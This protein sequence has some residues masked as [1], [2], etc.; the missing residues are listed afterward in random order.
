MLPPTIV[1]KAREK[2]LDAIGITDHNSAENVVSV[3]RAAAKSGLSVVMGMEITSREDVHALAYF[4]RE[5]ELMEMQGFVYRHLPGSN[6]EEKFGQQ[7]ITDKEGEPCDINNKLLIGATTLSIGEIVD[8]IHRL[9]GL[10]VASHIDREA[11]G[12]LGQLGF[13]PQ[14]LQLDA[15][16][17][18]SPRFK[19][20]PAG[21]P[22]VTSSDAHCLADIGKNVTRFCVEE[23]TVPEIKRALLNKNGRFIATYPGHS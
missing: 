2:G 18:S 8:T 15:L 12:I 6:D 9:N 13:I 21:F 23:M 11:Y 3:K 19:D 1:A 20:I 14:G 17:I 22:V 16:E 7:I 5:E 10:A 4:D